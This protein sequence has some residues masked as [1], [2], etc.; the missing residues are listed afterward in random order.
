VPIAIKGRHY[1]LAWVAV[2]LLA[3]AIVS[4]RDR[5]GFK[6]AKRIEALEHTHQVVSHQLMEVQ[7]DINNRTSPGQ[8]RRVGERLGLRIPTDS[9][10]EQVGVPRS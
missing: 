9:E 10:I 7:A 2:L 1:A 6:V 8:L 3:A 4:L 5:R